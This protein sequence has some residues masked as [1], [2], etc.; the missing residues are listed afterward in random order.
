WWGLT[1]VRVWQLVTGQKCRFF[2]KQL[3]KR[4][5]NDPPFNRMAQMT[6]RE[7]SAFSPTRR[8]LLAGAGALSLSSLIFPR[9]AAAASGGILRVRSY[10]DLQVLDPAFM[11]SQSDGDIM[12]VIFSKLVTRPAGDEWGWAPG[13]VE[14]IE[15]LDDKTI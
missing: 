6:K 5:T 15:Q 10:S 3:L 12:Q 14:S 4:I 9:N 13:D 2:I 11:M 1:P 7:T 8:Q